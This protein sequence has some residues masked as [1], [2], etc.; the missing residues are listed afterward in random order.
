MYVCVHFYVYFKYSY[1][2]IVENVIELWNNFL[3]IMTQYIYF[4][5]KSS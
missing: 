2:F 4:L 1:L 3:T 5:I